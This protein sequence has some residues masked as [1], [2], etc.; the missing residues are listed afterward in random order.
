RLINRRLPILA[1]SLDIRGVLD[2]ES[3]RCDEIAEGIVARGMPAGP[4]LHVDLEAPQLPDAPHHLVDADHVVSDM[5]QARRPR[6]NREPVMPFVT[7]QEH[8]EIA[9]P[10]T[11]LEPEDVD[12][13]L[14]CLLVSGRMQHDMTDLLGERF[15][16]LEPPSRAGLDVR[17]DLE[18]QSVRGEESKPV[19]AAEA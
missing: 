17:R 8:H 18:R 3:V 1:D 15:T 5:I 9:E 11:D 16:R 19:A 10:I 14:C 12:P 13:E 4:P 6:K 7:A 2:G